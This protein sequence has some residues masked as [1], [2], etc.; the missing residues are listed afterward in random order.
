V[1][2]DVNDLVTLFPAVIPIQK[3]LATGEV[4][5]IEQAEVLRVLAE[6]SNEEDGDKIMDEA[7]KNRLEEFGM[8]WEDIKAEAKGN[9]MIGPDYRREAA[10]V[11][12]QK[13][14]QQKYRR[15]TTRSGGIRT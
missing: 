1:R 5:Q 10:V 14:T 13:S 11:A 4:S 6:I 7:A 3:Q 8:T 15:I 2:E 9:I 12:I